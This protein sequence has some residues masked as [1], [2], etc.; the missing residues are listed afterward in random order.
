MDRRLW[1]RRGA[2]FSTPP[3]KGRNLIRP[4]NIPAHYVPELKYFSDK[5]LFSPWEAR[6]AFW[7]QEQ[8]PK[9]EQE[10]IQNAETGR[11]PSGSIN[12]NELMFNQQAFC[13]HRPCTTWPHQFREGD[14]KMND[15][16]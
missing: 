9:P 6:G 15:E 13:Y 10:S 11:S 2:V 3:H 1:R 16:Q 5:F 12:H 8:R 4:V 7:V 14:K